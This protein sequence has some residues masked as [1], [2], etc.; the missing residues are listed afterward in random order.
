LRPY[1]TYPSVILIIV[2]I[3]DLSHHLWFADWL[4]RRPV[5]RHRPE[6]VY[7]DVFDGCDGAC[8]FCLG[9][10][11]VGEPMDDDLYRHIVAEMKRWGVRELSLSTNGEPT[12]HPDLPSLVAQGAQ[13]GLEVY[14]ATGG[15]RIDDAMAREL[16]HAGIS[17]IAVSLETIPLGDR[18]SC[19]SG[20]AGMPLLRNI[21]ASWERSL[22]GM[23]ALLRARGSN[24]LPRLTVLLPIP[25][26]A[27]PNVME[28][29]SAAALSHLSHPP[30]GL[31][32]LPRH[33]WHGA[34]P[35]IQTRARKPHFVCQHPW[36]G[37]YLSRAGEAL[38][39]Y[40]DPQRLQAVD[41]VADKRLDTVW[42]SEPMQAVRRAHRSALFDDLPLCARCRLPERANPLGYLRRMLTEQWRFGR[43]TSRVFHWYC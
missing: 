3:P 35:G 16:V 2:K 5:P 7:L 20:L 14:F 37:L 11:V 33:D 41:S 39:C 42:R 13:S 40:F 26:D 36:R 30:D 28:A 17:G 15:H 25:S 8:R 21:P 43:K 31:L 24:V 38:T 4:A 10:G 9:A 32:A 12:L 23:D 29:L 27:P 18:H 6:F 22:A 19:L 1:I 34:F